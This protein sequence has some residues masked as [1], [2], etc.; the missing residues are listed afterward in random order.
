MS[1]ETLTPPIDL[2]EDFKTLQM[3]IFDDIG[4]E[5][6]RRLVNYFDEASLKSQ[7]MQVQ[8]TDFEDKEFA[9]MIHEAF[10]AARRIVLLAWKTAHGSELVA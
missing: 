6:T 2:V 7:E 3:L 10:L 9:R 4:G 8:S 5:K 1:T